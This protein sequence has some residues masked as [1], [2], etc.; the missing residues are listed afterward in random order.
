[1][2]PSAP[3]IRRPV[4][5]TLLTIG[6]A[7]A[8]FFA[9]LQL[10]VAPLPQVDFPTI[11]VFATMPGASPD[12]MA[13]TVA[14]PLERHLGIIADVAEMTSQSTVGQT[15]ITLQFGLNRN[16]D[17]A[18]RDVQAA[19]N[20]ARADLP[21][22]LR[23]NPTYRKVNPADSPVAILAMTSDT[24]TRGQ[25][26]DAASTVVQQGLSQID[27]IG[28][29]VI[30]GASLPAVRAELNPLALFKYGIGLEDVRAALAS[31]NAHSPKGALEDGERRF[32]IYTND[33]A[34][35]AA[36]YRPLVIAYRNGAPVRL[37]DVGEVRDSVENLR[38]QGLSNGKPAVL[39][40][41]YRQPGANI[42]ETVDR[43][44][45]VLPQLEASIPSA[46][47]VEVTMDRTKTIKSSLH[48][49]QRTLLIA[50]A[51][52][53]LV[54]FLFLRNLCATLIPT[55]AVPVSLIGT[56]GAMYLL[57]Y[58]L[59]NLSLMA[60]TI[61]TG[62]VV[63]DAIVVL[64]NVTRH[65]EAGMTRMQAA[66]Q[67][68]RE[69]GFTVLSMSVSLIAVFV[70]ILLMGGII[71]RLFREFAMTLSVAIMISLVVS[72]TTTPMM[73]AYLLPD[74]RGVVHGRLY[75]VSERAFAG[76]LALYDRTLQR[77]LEWPAL[78]I[79]S[80]LATLGFAIYLFTI[81]PKGFIPQQDN[82]LMIGGI[83]ADQSISFQLMQEKL[84]EFVDILGKDPAVEA[85][86]GFT[87]GSQTNSGF[88]FVV[89]KPLTERT[90]SVQQVMSRLRPQLNRV[91]GAR[92]FLQPATDIRAGGRASFAQY[93]YTLLAD[94]TD[95]I[96]DWAPK[97]E[98]A[99]QRLPQLTDVNLD[100][101][102]KGLEAEL[103][104]D[105]A[106]A[107]RL[108]LTVAQID[109]TL[110]DAFG[111][112]QVST[113]Y[114]AQNQYHVVM[115]VAPEFWQNPET[116]SQIYV[117]TSGGTVSGTQATQPLAGTVAAKVPPASS[118]AAATTTAQIAGNVARNAANNAIGNTGRNSTSTGAA[119]ST[120][121][122]TMVPLSAF[123][124]FGPG[125]TPLAVNHQNLFVASTISF[126]LA[127]NVSLSQATAAIEDEMHRLGVPPSI[128][129]GFQGTAQ[130]FQQSLAN[131]PYLIA[132]AVLA[133]YIVLGVL[134]ESYVHPITILSTL[135]S[136]G[137]GAVLALI[138]TNTEFSIMALIGV[139]LLIGIVKKNAIM[140]IDFA[141]DAERSLGLSSREAIYVACLKRFRPI[142]MTTMAAMFGAVPLAI[143]FGEGAELRHPLGISIVGGLIVSQ[144][145]T[146]Y[147]TPVIYLYLD[148]FRLWGRQRWRRRHPPFH[149][150]RIPEPGE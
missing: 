46:I 63:D 2:N 114:A 65:I 27:G 52:V 130:L 30:G 35:R 6:I 67:G 45:A 93:Q 86:N 56:F 1:V 7:L 71:G 57:G 5:T 136:A 103:I 18:A 89:L 78:V 117:S 62:F 75:R 38:N 144:L 138:A 82:G 24:L 10:P 12:T 134:Y 32:Q 28:Q 126:N 4:A 9:Y 100:Q 83:Q 77:A 61:S 41:L 47:N 58:S 104:I 143:A 106:T 85:V 42:I 111:Q 137:A 15:R 34:N 96:Y 25:I 22:S 48:D 14:T 49:V 142:M 110:Y 80:L 81:V 109:N 90:A 73:C 147:T 44:K 102:Q 105:R 17:G 40:F 3:F 149:S 122:E 55:V 16:I 79:L 51:L 19:V 98:A 50:I 60:L 29:V 74:G 36:D 129:G 120:V 127:P 133:V 115:E 119:V 94:N 54:V 13:A 148:R 108:G 91:A 26:Y 70:P 72:L 116:L 33:Q 135:P 68:A 43:V 64:E 87:G 139:I 123:A 145:L 37:T 97:V 113:I 118:T 88:V 20:A 76:M 53:V 59:D 69:V 11:S 92:L 23:Q 8:G 124:H 150:G 146:L 31:A 141:L 21:T 112:R 140:M 125:N 128:Q 84:T 101:Q 131:E 107:A 39:V 95:E 99:L 66:L 121:H 132:A